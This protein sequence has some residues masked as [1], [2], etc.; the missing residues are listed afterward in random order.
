MYVVIPGSMPLT[1]T[2]WAFT[3]DAAV[4]MI[5]ALTTAVKKRRIASSNS[6]VQ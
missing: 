6:S 5:A 3:S 1:N 4:V 2:P